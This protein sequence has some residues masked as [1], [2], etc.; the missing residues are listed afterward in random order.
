MTTNGL[1]TPIPLDQFVD[2]PYQS[3]EVYDN[4]ELA[5]LALSIKQNGLLQIPIGRRRADGMIELD[6]GHRRLRAHQLL[7]AEEPLRFGTMPVVL[8]Q[9]SDEELITHSWAENEQ[10]SG[11][12]AI[13]KAKAFQRYMEGAGWSQKQLAQ[14]LGLNQ[15][16]VSNLLRLLKL[17][18]SVQQQVLNRSLSERQ[19]AA[20]L[21]LMELPEAFLTAPRHIWC[22]G[23]EY[24]SIQALMDGA[25]AVADSADLRTTVQQI[26]N[27]HTLDLARQSWAT[28]PLPDD[29]VQAA[30]CKDCVRRLK[31]ANRCPDKACAT[32]KATIWSLRQ[33][34]AAAASVGLPALPTLDYCEYS[35]IRDANLDLLRAKATERNCGSLGVMH[36]TAYVYGVRVPDHPECYMVCGKGR[37]G[38]MQSLA[39]SKDPEASRAAK[40][41]LERTTI[42]EDILPQT[43]Q[44][45]RSAF[46]EPGLPL[47]KLLLSRY[48]DHRYASDWGTTLDAETA[49]TRLI[50]VLV[51]HKVGNPEYWSIANVRSQCA[52][53]LQLA[54]VA[55]PW[56][57]PP[58]PDRLAELYAGA[59]DTQAAT[60][61]MDLAARFGLDAELAAVAMLLQL[62]LRYDPDDDHLYCWWPDGILAMHGSTD[63]IESW[64]SEDAWKNWSDRVLHGASVWPAGVSMLPGDHDTAAYEALACLLH[65]LAIAEASYAEGDQTLCDDILSGDLV[66]VLDD[67]SYEALAKRI[68][69]LTQEAVVAV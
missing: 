50:E 63:V 66:D 24:P 30:L 14:K 44:A 26:I 18:D 22:K 56:D 7:A 11:L 17:P 1:P 57:I 64:L 33:A 51:E 40:T 27:Q 39:M 10:R 25:S 61:R 36:S 16:T 54:E 35:D 48:V 52:E 34:D 45:L 32:R 31:S 55:V 12:T 41:R 47:W 67:A 46:Q 69:A 60:D 21:P 59:F 58:A 9:L 5:A 23:R 43:K 53:L 15:S 49:M 3:R 68:S 8:K 19:A 2:N 28:Q 20:L 6:I 29:Q 13:E 65:S 37:C 38:C 4:D 62:K 42:K